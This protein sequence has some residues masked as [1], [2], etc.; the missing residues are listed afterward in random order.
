MR[1]RSLAIFNRQDNTERLH[2]LLLLGVIV[3]S[4][5]RTSSQQKPQN[6]GR[7]PYLVHPKRTRSLFNISRVIFL[8][9]VNKKLI[10]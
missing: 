6:R 4:R 9:Y 7:S 2:V 1:I 8:I 3:R 5:Q 10:K